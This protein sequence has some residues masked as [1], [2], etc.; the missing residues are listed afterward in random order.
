[1]CDYA[2]IVRIKNTHIPNQAWTM[3]L[4]NEN[5]K[6]LMHLEWTRVLGLMLIHY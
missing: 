6:K 2:A 1:M 5:V 3:G 4:L